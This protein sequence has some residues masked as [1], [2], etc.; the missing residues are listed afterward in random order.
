MNQ[1]KI[2]FNVKWKKYEKGDGVRVKLDGDL[3]QNNNQKYRPG[4]IIRSYP[5]H[6]KIQLF[7]TNPKNSYA[8]VTINSKIQYIKS[9]YNRSV[10][11]SEINQRWI[12]KKTKLPVKINKNNILFK[13]IAEMEF[14]EI[15]GKSISFSKFKNQATENQQLKK[16][17]CMQSLKLKNRNCG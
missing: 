16:Q 2:S 14:K 17:I 5:T 8:S 4:I 3:D 11:I 12:D 9:K 1:N 7:S 13:Q 15:S 6:I 10:N